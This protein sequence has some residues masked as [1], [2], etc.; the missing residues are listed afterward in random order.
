M[1]QSAHYLPV[2]FLLPR[3]KANYF[4]VNVWICKTLS[5]ICYV[6]NGKQTHNDMNDTNY[7]FNIGKSTWSVNIIGKTGRVYVTKTSL[8]R[9]M[10]FGK[11][12]EIWTQ[13]RPNYKSADMKCTWT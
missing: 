6:N 3:I 13:P 5:Y 7:N 4:C 12:F 1:S 10:R 2:G 11:C 9:H 8:P